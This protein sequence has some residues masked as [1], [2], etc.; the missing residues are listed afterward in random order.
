VDAALARIDAQM[1]DPAIYGQDG[2]AELAQ[3]AQRRGVL[4]AEKD[5]LEAD[6]LALADAAGA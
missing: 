4:A 1:A 6:W 3:L 2:G 5:A